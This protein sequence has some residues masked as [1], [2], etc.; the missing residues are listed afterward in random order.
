MFLWTNDND[1]RLEKAPCLELCRCL[2]IGIFKVNRVATC[3]CCGLGTA[4]KFQALPFWPKSSFTCICFT[5]TL[6]EWQT[7]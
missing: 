1:F 7:V 5:P 3:V 6:M 4:L 2:F